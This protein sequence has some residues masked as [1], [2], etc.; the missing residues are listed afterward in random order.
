MTCL[1]TA[2][3]RSYHQVSCESSLLLGKRWPRELTKMHTQQTMKFLLTLALLALGSPFSKAAIF[4]WTIDL[5]EVTVDL[6]N[7]VASTEAVQFDYHYFGVFPEED[8]NVTLE[9]HVYESG[10]DTLYASDGQNTADSKRVFRQS[11]LQNDPLENDL[12]VNVNLDL[13]NI[14]AATEVWSQD[15][16]A[17]EAVLFFCGRL[18]V[19]Y[20]DDQDGR[21]K[22]FV[23][24]HE[25]DMNATIDLLEGGGFDVTDV[26]FNLVQDIEDQEFDKIAT[27]NYEMDVFLC[28]EDTHVALANANTTV[29]QGDPV[30]FCVSVDSSVTETKV[31]VDSIHDFRYWSTNVNDGNIQ[32]TVIAV[33]NGEINNLLTDID[34][35]VRQG[36]CRVKFIV[37]AALFADDSE[38]QKDLEVG[39]NALIAF[40]T[41]SGAARR[42]VNIRGLIEEGGQALSEYAYTVGPFE[43]YQGAT[44][45]VQKE[46]DSKG[47]L[48]F[49]V[50]AIVL[51]LFGFAGLQYY[52]Y[53]AKQAAHRV[54]K[55]VDASTMDTPV[56]RGGDELMVDVNMA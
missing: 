11:F 21:N 16:G 55:T 17:T 43:G 13:E 23:N 41:D 9:F 36:I 7:D 4:N 56:S 24:F 52:F 46:E 15:A 50:I 39:G 25:T 19:Y 38:E 1:Q 14:A 3:S 45:D 22:T 32:D 5:Q 6:N 26:N 48:V 29:T 37:D 47:G 53:Y 49:A 51:A 34:C 35:T 42:L 27:V 18:E 30:V 44:A 40:G 31:Y 12:T 2:P 54:G 33:S 8:G 20:G 10:C 28:N